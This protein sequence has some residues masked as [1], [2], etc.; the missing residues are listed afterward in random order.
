MN[1]EHKIDLDN[2]LCFKLYSVSRK[3]TR[4]YQ[5]MLSKFH[6]TYPQYVILLVLFQKNKIDFKSLCE[7]VNLRPG[8]LTPI[9][10][11]LENLGYV[12]RIHN[13]KDRRRLFV[14]LTEEGKRI[15]SDLVILSNNL[16]NIIQLSNRDFVTLFNLL[17]SIDEKLDEQNEA[18]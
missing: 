15:E 5:P 16:K 7:K 13:P 4:E 8:T 9:I 3:I 10:K 18:V 2:L 1:V 11:R 12:N 14:S 17:N 6:L